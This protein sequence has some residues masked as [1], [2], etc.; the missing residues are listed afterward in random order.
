MRGSNHARCQN[1]CAAGSVRTT[2]GISAVAGSET[3]AKTAAADCQAFPAPSSLVVLAA[4]CFE[5]L[6]DLIS[7][8]AALWVR[9][10]VK[11]VISI[12]TAPSLSVMPFRMEL[13]RI[14]A[15]VLSSVVDIV[16]R[17]AK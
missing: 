3:A 11:T 12:F 9:S 17:K 10:T 5:R 2:A 15:T 13:G 8:S 16:T 6:P 1:L 4:A 14:M 7:R